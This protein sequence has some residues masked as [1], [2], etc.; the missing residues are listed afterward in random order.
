MK[1][2]EEKQAEERM[3]A[4]EKRDTPPVVEKEEDKKERERVKKSTE[5]IHKQLARS[6]KKVL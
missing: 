5:R 6:N 2:Q 3:K 4:F 1:N